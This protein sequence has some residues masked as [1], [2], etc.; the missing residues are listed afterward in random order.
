[1]RLTLLTLLAYLDD[2]LDPT[3]ARELEK[4]IEESKFAT[5]LVHRIR[6]CTRRL[7][8]DA[9]KVNG[10]G[11]GLD[12]NSVSEF[13]DSTL[14]RDR[15][16]DFE[17]VCLESDRHLAEVASCHQILTLVVDQPAQV[18][19]GLRERIYRLQDRQMQ[20]LEAQP[21][22]EQ[23][24]EF[25]PVPSP[26][27]RRE[28]EPV[29]PPR[30][31]PLQPA[32]A[33]P[34]YMQE[35]WGLWPLF[36]A[37]GLAGVVLVGGWYL[38]GPGGNPISWLFSPAETDRQIA[39]NADSGGGS[40]P[41][42]VASEGQGETPA[43]SVADDG[44]GNSNGSVIPDLDPD[45]SAAENGSNE[46]EL[47]GSP[48][49][50]TSGAVN[51]VRPDGVISNAAGREDSEPDIGDKLAPDMEIARLLTDDQVVARFDVDSRLWQRLPRGSTILSGEQLIVLP[52][53]RPIISLSNGIQVMLDGNTAFQLR[54]SDQP[55]LPVFSLQYGHAIMT[56][57]GKN[58][59]RARLELG[60]QSGIVTIDGS[61]SELAIEVEKHLQ[62]GKEPTEGN[63][64]WIARCM[65][66]MGKV[67]WQSDDGE[68][69]E[70]NVGEALVSETDEPVRIE[71]VAAAPAWLTR[72]NVSSIDR[73]ASREL[74]GFL[75]SRKALTLLLEER[76]SFRRVE[77]RSLA[78]RCLASLGEFGAVLRELSE[79]KQRAYW[80]TAVETLREALVNS[81]NL[82]RKLDLELQTAYNRDAKAI[83]KVLCDYDQEQFEKG[84]AKQ[85]IDMLDHES[86]PVRVI[87]FETLRR[88]TGTTHNYNPERPAD[89]RR[90]AIL[91]WQQRL[92]EKAIPYKGTGLSAK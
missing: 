28:I 74:E 43:A 34:D 50:E 17:K 33:V 68:V 26:R 86:L 1:M 58:E 2:N 6:T 23:Q 5:D 64:I 36:L 67:R 78:A 41:L 30:A 45:K 27:S 79:E 9:P 70:I 89:E 22:H 25:D 31:M 90:K 73:Q 37:F 85:L 15:F 75:V 24:D 91:I 16:P 18:P 49:D 21:D 56:T 10:K 52:T 71:S 38:I 47:S 29:P 7:R 65:V 20:Q 39:L 83:M 42:D 8:L 51:D 48:V 32:A 55:E 46:D 40:S 53:F 84:G 57:A 19:V 72:K 62:I 3:D 59:L 81:P 92:K 61:T 14:P 60:G 80:H 69:A 88:L 11:M 63:V 77:V 66:T 4:K 35:S 44:D 54:T 87:A 82:A 76:T 13:L 12:A